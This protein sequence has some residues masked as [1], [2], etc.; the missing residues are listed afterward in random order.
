[1]EDRDQVLKYLENNNKDNNYNNYN[2]LELDF[3]YS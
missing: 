3:L 1:M 2:G